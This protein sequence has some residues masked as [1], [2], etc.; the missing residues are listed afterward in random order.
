MQREWNTERKAV[1]EQKSRFPVENIR[2]HNNTY[3]TRV[4]QRH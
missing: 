1:F 4:I 3:K 2:T